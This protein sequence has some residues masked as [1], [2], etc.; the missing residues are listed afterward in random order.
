ME[1]KRYTG[2]TLPAKLFWWYMGRPI[3]ISEGVGHTSSAF[4]L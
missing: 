1:L 2:Y 4:D 3:P